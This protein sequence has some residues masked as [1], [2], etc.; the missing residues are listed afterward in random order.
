MTTGSNESVPQGGLPPPDARPGFR[1]PIAFC[2]PPFL[3]GLDSET[4]AR[5]LE[6]I[7]AAWSHHSTAIEGN[8]LTLEQ[9]TA[10]LDTGKYAGLPAEQYHEVGGQAEALDLLWTLL[11]RE[12]ETRDL[13]DMH[14]VLLP[15]VM[16]RPADP[17]GR[18]KMVPNGIVSRGPDGRQVFHMLIEPEYV[19]SLMTEFV[20]EINEASAIGVRPGNGHVVF[21]RL[22][23]GFTNIHP[24]FDGNGRMARMIANIPLLRS[25]LAPVMIS[26][27]RR[28]AY[29]AS[30]GAYSDRTGELSGRN[31]TWPAG[32]DWPE[33]E[34][35][36]S[37]CVHFCNILIRDLLLERG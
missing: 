1:P 30:L 19:P 18:W 32:H 14:E 36:C 28:A 17:V 12:L 22:H 33:F 11:D 5:A 6:R 20:K 24:F 16:R 29:M 23:I 21:A 15:P 34:R 31:G 37:G 7:R 8:I 35:F 13:L 27:E 9:T 3:V 25:G 4:Q 2:P 26:V 10:W